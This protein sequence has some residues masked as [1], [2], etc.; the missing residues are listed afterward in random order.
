MNLQGFDIG[1]VHIGGPVLLGPMAGVSDMPFRLLCRE[2]GAALVCTE[3]ISAKAVLYKN[4]G[5]RELMRMHPQESPVSLQLFGSDPEIVSAIAAGIEEEPFDVLDINMGCP[6]QKVVSN[7]EG[8]ALMKDP[9]LAAEIVR[10]T[11][12]AVHKPV[13]VKF[14]KG[15]DADHVNAVEFAKRMEDAGAAALAVHGRTREQFYSGTADWDIIRQVKEAV[16]VPVLGSGDV[17]D[18]ESA[19]KMLDETGCDGVMIARAAQGNPWIFR[20]VNHYLKTGEVLPRPEAAEKV[21]L[22]LRHCDMMLECKGEY[23]GVREMRKHLSWY[24]T[25]LRNSSSFRG[26]LNNMETAEEL[27]QAVLQLFGSGES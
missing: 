9:A 16:S 21:E 27:K 12:Q 6:V 25:G 24:S 13:T 20:E 3:M 11:V 14:R 26:V 1:N 18:G 4:K 8:S 10:Q 7:K 23:I 22:L 15:F 2:Q 5:T 17:T 19:K